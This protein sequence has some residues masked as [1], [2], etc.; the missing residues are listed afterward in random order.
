[1][2]GFLIPTIKVVDE[3]SHSKVYQVDITP[4]NSYRVTVTGQAPVFEE[5][6]SQFN[7]EE[8]NSFFP[9]G[10]AVHG[11]GPRG[12]E[13]LTVCT[14]LRC[15]VFN[16]A[17][18]SHNL[19]RNVL[20][21]LRDV[22]TCYGWR[23]D[24]YSERLMLRNQRLSLGRLTDIRTLVSPQPNMGLGFFSVLVHGAPVPE[25]SADWT[26]SSRSAIMNQLRETVMQA[27]ICLE[28]GA[29]YCS[30]APPPNESLPRVRLSHATILVFFYKLYLSFSIS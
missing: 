21:F 28:V 12:A 1:M 24:S 7:V 27:T 19:S 11:E 22:C 13:V 25:P 3:Q 4:T 8:G 18:T 16:L 29:F 15:I 5:W 30:H 14:K 2:A 10:V 9:V 17:T 20:V 6:V 23:T 26:V